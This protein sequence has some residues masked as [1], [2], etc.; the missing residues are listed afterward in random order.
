M[1][2][3]QQA[4]VYVLVRI[5]GLIINAGARAGAASSAIPSCEGMHGSAV[6]AL[7]G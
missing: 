6:N 1:Q 5:A 7:G 3:Y 4:A 2:N